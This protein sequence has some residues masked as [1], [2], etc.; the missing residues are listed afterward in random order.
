M[1][2]HGQCGT[3]TG[4]QW[5]AT[6]YALAMTG[7]GKESS[8]RFEYRTNTFVIARRERSERRGNPSCLGGDDPVSLFVYCNT[9]DRHRLSAL[10]MTRWGKESS[11]RFEYRTN[12]FVIA[13]RER[14]ERRGNQSCLGGD[15]PVSL[16]VYCNTVD[17]HGLRPR[18]D[19]R[20]AIR[21]IE[22]FLF[23]PHLSLRGESGL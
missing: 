1:D 2:A 11:V 4:S 23:H 10:A 12:T 16:F 21:Q 19:N 9:V 6:G 3:I 14:S 13:R 7:W 5:I 15:D 17:H 8:V 18:D 20:F 22:I